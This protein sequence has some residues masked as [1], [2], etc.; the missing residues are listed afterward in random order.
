MELTKTYELR[1]KLYLEI[2]NSEDIWGSARKFPH[3]YSCKDI[4]TGF[5]QLVF[6]ITKEKHIFTSFTKMVLEMELFANFHA[7]FPT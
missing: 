5:F 4:L 3:Q 2:S 1:E 6:A 7:P